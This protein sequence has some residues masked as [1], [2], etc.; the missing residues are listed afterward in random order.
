MKGGRKRKKTIEP[1]D[2]FKQI[3]LKTYKLQ[4]SRNIRVLYTHH[5]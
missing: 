2:N 3:E 4:E 1:A 5:G